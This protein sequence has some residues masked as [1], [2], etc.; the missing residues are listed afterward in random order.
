MKKILFLILIINCS[1]NVYKLKA[2]EI[3]G[4]LDSMFTNPVWDGA[5]PWLI[6]HNYYYYY[7]HSS[8]KGIT[9][10]KSTRLTEKGE[11][12]VVWD[13]PKEGWNSM[14]L[15]A[16]E[17]HYI[18]GKWYIYYTGGV[19]GP[20]FIHQKAGVLEA[21]TDD[22]QGNYT[23]RGI[24]ATGED[25]LDNSK[26]IWAID[27]TVFEL[28]KKLYAVWSGW[29]QPAKT[30]KTPQHL[31]IAPM[32]NPYTISGKRVL[33]SSPVEKW[34]TGGPLDLQE[35]PQI[36][37]S[38]KDFFIIYSCRESWTKEY[39]LGQLRLKSLKSDPLKPENW[40]KSGPIFEGTEDV[41]GVG[42]CSFVKSPDNKEDWIIYHSKKGVEPNW[43]RDV[44]M[45]KFGWNKYGSP[46]FGKPVK[47]GLK[48]NRPSGEK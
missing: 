48:I 35:G 34:E 28:N 33:L 30:D 8:T 15:W 21:Q 16:P 38:D 29:L 45:Q 23:D 2:Q 13:R 12:K 31:Y 6:K 44:R 17:L 3:E 11:C 25:P 24:L 37:Q 18:R 7:C 36:L 32:S 40:I 47:A 19:S 14:H 10:C 46:D 22:P 26:A 41:Y 39:R 43:N 20:P 27:M 4:D 9:V 1:L 5:D 42:H